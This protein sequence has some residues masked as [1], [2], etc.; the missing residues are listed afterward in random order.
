MV[1]AHQYVGML[2]T[3]QLSAKPGEVYRILGVL[4][5]GDRG[6]RMLE[7]IAVIIGSQM[8][9]YDKPGGTAFGVKTLPHTG[10]CRH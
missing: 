5:G 8:N 3:A 2:L 6:T 9:Q 7:D 10:A 4:P 1:A